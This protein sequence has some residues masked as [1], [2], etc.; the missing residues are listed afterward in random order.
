MAHDFVKQPLPFQNLSSHIRLK[1]AHNVG[2]D[3][4]RLRNVNAGARKPNEDAAIM[5]RA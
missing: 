3:R 4:P 5:L 2:D 1:P